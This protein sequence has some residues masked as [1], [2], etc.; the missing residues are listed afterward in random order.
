VGVFRIIN[1]KGSTS[2]T[3][4]GAT[5]HKQAMFISKILL[6]QLVASL[7]CTFSATFC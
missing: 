3:K 1:S 4:F 6:R 5:S 7:Y 2:S